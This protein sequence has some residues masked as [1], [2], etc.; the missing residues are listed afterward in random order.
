MKLWIVNNIIKNKEISFFIL[1]VLALYVTSLLFYW[2]LGDL[3][4]INRTVPDVLFV[5]IPYWFISSKWKWS[6]L[7]PIWAFSVYAEVNILYYRFFDE[8]MPMSSFFLWQNVDSLVLDNVP[9]VFKASDLFLFVPAISISVLYKY[10]FSKQFNAPGFVGTAMSVRVVAVIGSCLF[11]AVSQ[12]DFLFDRSKL[13]ADDCIID[14]GVT[15][16]NFAKSKFIIPV[17][18]LK[19]DLFILGW[20]AY[21][22]KYALYE[23]Q[24]MMDE[25]T[26]TQD[27]IHRIEKFMQWKHENQPPLPVDSV[28]VGKNLILIIVESLNSWVVNNEYASREITP[29]LNR[30]LKEDGTV[31]CLDMTSQVRE[32]YSSDGQLIYNTGLLPAANCATAVRYGDNCFIGIADVLPDY[33]SFEVIVESGKYWNHRVTTHSYG[34]DSL[35]ENLIDKYADVDIPY[36]RMLFL[37]AEILIESCRKPFFAELTTLTMHAP[38][39]C[40]GVDRQGWIDSL[41]EIND[42]HKNYL[43]ACNAFDRELGD[44]IIWLRDNDIYDK[45]VIVL[46]SDHSMKVSDDMLPYGVTP[47]TFIA[48]NTGLTKGI[49]KPVGQVDVYPTILDIMGI[50]QSCRWR[51]LGCSMLDERLGSSVM[52][53][54]RVFGEDCLWVARQIEAWDVSN[55]ILRGDYF[56]VVDM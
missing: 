27:E 2:G 54:S 6:I 15:V 43:Q 24:G 12:F 5:L 23:M 34:Y 46:A 25:R 7:I 55:D 8:M 19:T 10:M 38:F 26:L 32:G 36:D 13:E 49:T 37:E 33:H 52:Y 30:L 18:E 22:C 9:S 56:K 3:F 45:S 1:S 11:F 20:P 16:G 17:G 40:E 50:S 39:N 42:V 29:V 53:P 14:E 47:V 48:V 44:F 31:Y 35:Y 4:R 21:V 28:N 51:G 41:P